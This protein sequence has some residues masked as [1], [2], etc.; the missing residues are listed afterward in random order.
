[1]TV[2]PE[3]FSVGDVHVRPVR[4]P[5]ASDPHRW[6]WRA[7]R[8][9]TE[10]LWSGRATRAE[11]EAAVVEL[12]YRFVAGEDACDVRSGGESARTVADVLAYYLGNYKE[13]VD[14][15][16][17]KAS[18]LKGY[19][20]QRARIRK[21]IGSFLV[22]RLT[23]RVIETWI[24]GR[25]RS[26]IEAPLTVRGDLIM[27]RAALTWA[28]SVDLCEPVD[29]AWPRI[30]GVRKR[31]KPTPTRE[32]VRA[33]WAELARWPA[34]QDAFLFLASTGA[35]QG[36]LN[37]LSWTDVDLKATA[38]SL[39]GKT[40]TRL[41][42]VAGDCLAMLR[43]RRMASLAGGP[44]FGSRARGVTLCQRKLPGACERAKVERL[45]PHALRRFV[46][47]ELIERGTDAKTYE[48]IMGHTWA[49]GLRDYAQSRAGT[50]RGAVEAA[51]LGSIL[52]QRVDEAQ[53]SEGS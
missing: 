45:T 27:L 41:V 51:G 35:R 8:T 2:R 7:M 20:S 39:T 53:A 1:M 19:M 48:A 15:G 6:Y 31:A 5:I 11:A 29:L 38:V 16:Q 44:V 49:V 36:E 14:A 25:L 12:V 10:T 22:S 3:R 40:G 30:K 13:R 46:S 26:K 42:P 52:G 34:E 50:R 9:R 18:T 23:T 21:G 32:Q 33:V 43:R 37:A 17:R 47:S 28:A 24:R 4:P